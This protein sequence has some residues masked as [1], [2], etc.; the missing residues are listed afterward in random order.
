MSNSHGFTLAFLLVGAV[1]CGRTEVDSQ[2]GG[3]GDGGS[4]DAKAE[5]GPVD[6]QEVKAE[7]GFDSIDRGGPELPGA[8]A[9]E[10]SFDYGP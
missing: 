10:G 3:R 5:G 1:A 4:Q 9:F 2:G 7:G 6:A 8:C